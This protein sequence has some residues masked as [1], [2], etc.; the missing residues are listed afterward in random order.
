ML[1]YLITTT[2]LKTVVEL[3]LIKVWGKAVMLDIYLC[4]R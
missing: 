2:L 3:S 4:R 1:T